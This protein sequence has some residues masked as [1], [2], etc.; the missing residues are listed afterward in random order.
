MS[1][2]RESPR[3]P[4]REQQLR[5]WQ[6][7]VPPL[8]HLVEDAIHDYEAGRMNGPHVP[9]HLR[10]EPAK[11]GSFETKITPVKTK[12]GTS[13]KPISLP[14]VVK[15][16]PRKTRIDDLMNEDGSTWRQRQLTEQFKVDNGYFF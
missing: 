5:E 1:H 15:R 4:P 10:K 2:G 3:Y 9:A 7:A 8:R 12:F 16:P 13:S 11:S 6:S 14:P